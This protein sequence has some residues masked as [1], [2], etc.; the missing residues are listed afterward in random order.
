MSF[1]SR[2]LGGNALALVGFVLC[3]GFAAPGAAQAPELTQAIQLEAQGGIA[4]KVPAWKKVKHDQ[5]VVVLERAPV[6]KG[7]AF[8]LLLVAIEEGPASPEGRI[9]WPRIRD[10]IT[11]AAKASGSTL[12]LKLGGEWNGVKGLKGQRLQGTLRSHDETVKVAMIALVGPGFLV[13]VSGLEPGEGKT[14]SALVDR[15]AATVE[16][17][18]QP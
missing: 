11:A 6:A 16:R 13:T 2:W 7:A 5:A 17:G 18:A 1:L 9:D 12:A 3:L 10:N 14:V 4:C 15:V 8:L